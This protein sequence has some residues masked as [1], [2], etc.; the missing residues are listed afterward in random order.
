[1]DE[2]LAKKLQ[3]KPG[4]R[5]KVMNPPAGYLDRL[6]SLPE[7]AVF[8]DEGPADWVQL[9]VRNKAEVDALA[10]LGIAA[11][12]PGGVLWICY[13]KGGAKAG[14]DIN[15]DTGWEAMHGAG[16]G[17]VM[18]VALDEAWSALRWRPESDVKRKGGVPWSER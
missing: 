2:A 13:P 11:V 12:S 4:L 1:M 15:R 9:F 10:P 18:Q 17:P 14:T 6:G 8:V 16:W 5:V 7:G 3:L